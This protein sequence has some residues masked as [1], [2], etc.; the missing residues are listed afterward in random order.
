M[1]RECLTWWDEDPGAWHD[2][3]QP[4]GL[5]RLTKQLWVR[6]KKR[7]LLHQA[8]LQLRA[9]SLHRRVVLE[10]AAAASPHETVLP[11][12]ASDF[13]GCGHTMNH[14]V[15][16]VTTVELGR[17]LS[18]IDDTQILMTG[19]SSGLPLRAPG[20]FPVVHHTQH[21]SVYADTLRFRPSFATGRQDD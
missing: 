2:F 10:A 16:R 3:A 19:Y 15:L 13:D 14:P 5:D 18:L 6:M 7:S 4:P 17:P 11:L 20:C 9:R 21:F 1:A 12:P 8:H